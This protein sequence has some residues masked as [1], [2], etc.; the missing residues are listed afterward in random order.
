MTEGPV[1]SGNM[2]I[3]SVRQLLERI[4]MSLVT[5]PEELRI[6]VSTA[7]DATVFAV[8]VA[9]VDVSRVIGDDGRTVRAT[10]MILGAVG[11]RHKHQF[12]LEIEERPDDELP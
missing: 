9:P 10:R 11:L 3:D 2:N 6:Q 4:L 7:G 12:V 1:Q 5:L 8:R